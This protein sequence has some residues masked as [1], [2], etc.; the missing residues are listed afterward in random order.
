MLVADDSKREIWRLKVYRQSWKFPSM[1][2]LSTSA[3]H[4]C[5]AGASTF[6][7]ETSLQASRRCGQLQASSW[8]S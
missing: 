4:F 5:L 7:C 6:F 3:R 1:T 8:Q 2:S